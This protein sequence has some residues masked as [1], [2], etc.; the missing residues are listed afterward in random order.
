MIINENLMLKYHIRLN[1]Y[2]RW[3]HFKSYSNKEILQLMIYFLLKIICTN[4]TDIQIINKNRLNN[5]I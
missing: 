1:K 2:E 3:R 5:Y 4:K